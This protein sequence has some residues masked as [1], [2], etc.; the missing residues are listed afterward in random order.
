MW[1][2]FLTFVIHRCFGKCLYLLLDLEG[3]T[4]SRP[5]RS[6]GSQN[7]N[8]VLAVY[9]LGH[10]CDLMSVLGPQQGDLRLSGPPPGRDASGGART[11]DK[12]VPADLRADSLATEPPKPALL[13]YPEISG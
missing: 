6:E 2:G 13:Q 9:N 3:V 1:M 10:F 4:G 7:A 5:G 8:T 12:R 11:S